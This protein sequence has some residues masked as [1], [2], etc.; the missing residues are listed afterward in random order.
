MSV[1]KP[2]NTHNIFVN[3]SLEKLGLF[4]NVIQLLID[5]IKAI[6]EPF[7]GNEFNVRIS[8]L[9]SRDITEEAFEEII[10]KLVHDNSFLTLPLTPER[11][12][13][14]YLFLFPKGTSLEKS[15]EKLV[16]LSHQ[17]R[18]IDKNGTV[19]ILE[20]KLEDIKSTYTGSG[21]RIEYL[22]K[23]C[24]ISDATKQFPIAKVAIAKK[25]VKIDNDK[26]YELMTEESYN[27]R[28]WREIYDAVNGLNRNIRKATGI[29]KFVEYKD[30]G[31]RLNT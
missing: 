26:V 13:K 17:I 30:Q 24:E 28:S 22:G 15:Y 23:S 31:I 2:Q 19:E 21:L 16:K 8:E 10:K 12:K 11:F 6:P 14:H 27:K 1:E 29:V 4:R 25:G 3:L 18:L 7:A 5:E 20:F 9:N